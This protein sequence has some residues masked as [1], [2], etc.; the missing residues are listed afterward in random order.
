MM[1]KGGTSLAPYYEFEDRVPADTKAQVA[2][3]ADKIKAGELKVEIDD[4]E[5]KS[6]Y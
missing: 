4:N 1:A 6:T 5:P 2:E 3:L